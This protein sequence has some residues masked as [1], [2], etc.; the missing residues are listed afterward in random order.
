MI[1]VPVHLFLQFEMD[2]P[3]VNKIFATLSSDEFDFY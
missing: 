1:G 2:L 3:F